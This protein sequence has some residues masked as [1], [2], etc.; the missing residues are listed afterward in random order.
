[1]NTEELTKPP[2]TDNPLGLAS[3][4]TGHAETDTAMADDGLNVQAGTTEHTP[5]PEPTSEPSPFDAKENAAQTSD[6]LGK[7]HTAL[8]E[9]VVALAE[10]CGIGMAHNAH[11]MV[12]HIH[13]YVHNVQGW[14]EK[15]AAEVQHMRVK[16]AAGEYS[17]AGEPETQPD[18]V[19]DDTVQQIRKVFRGGQLLLTITKD[20][21]EDLA[22]HALPPQY[23]GRWGTFQ[24]VPRPEQGVSLP[25]IGEKQS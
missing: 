2:Q 20:H 9:K 18:G 14:M 3:E 4:A 15:A 25:G 16:L 10:T 24:D 22:I 13:T 17:P 1:M 12:D 11:E 19:Y 6:D 5:Q 23:R 21:L 7:E 8:I